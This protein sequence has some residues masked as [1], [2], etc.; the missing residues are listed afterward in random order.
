MKTIKSDIYVNYSKIVKKRIYQITVEKSTN[1]S[2]K[3]C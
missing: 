3:I 2:L 1:I